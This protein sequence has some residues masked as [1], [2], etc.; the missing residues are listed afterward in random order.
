MFRKLKWQIPGEALAAR[1]KFCQGP[2]PGCGPAVEKHCP[3]HSLNI[4]TFTLIYSTFVYSHDSLISFS[5]NK[6][7]LFILTSCAFNC[8]SLIIKCIDHTSVFSWSKNLTELSSGL[9]WVQEAVGR[10]ICYLRNRHVWT[11]LVV[12][13]HWH[14]PIS[15]GC[16]PPNGFK[17]VYLE[18]KSTYKDINWTDGGPEV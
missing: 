16:L 3:I 11:G 2:L 8:H 17:R 14:L 13:I 7:F 5:F 18:C 6:R 4:C 12:C 9:I 15:F 1:Y 10:E